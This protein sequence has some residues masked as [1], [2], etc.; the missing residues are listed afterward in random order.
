MFTQAEV[1]RLCQGYFKQ[2]CLPPVHLKG[3]IL[4][5]TKRSHCSL[6][7]IL[8]V[9][10]LLTLQS[11]DRVQARS[12]LPFSVPELVLNL[13]DAASAEAKW[14]VVSLSELVLDA[15]SAAEAEGAVGMSELA[16]AHARSFGVFK[17]RVSTK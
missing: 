15:L 16:L 2:F 6:S 7:G 10:I 13:N 12:P 3:S 11:I 4:P 8:I 17:D 5:P 14:S 1:T 9:I